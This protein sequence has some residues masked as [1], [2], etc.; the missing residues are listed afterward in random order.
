MT[1]DV[2]L[3]WDACDCCE[4]CRCIGPTEEVEVALGPLPP[5]RYTVQ[6]EGSS[7]VLD[8]WEPRACSVVNVDEVR[9]PTVLFDDQPFAMTL[10]ERDASSCSCQPHAS[11]DG[12]QARMDICDCCDVCDCIDRGYETSVASDPLPLGSRTISTSLGPRSLTVV[13]REQCGPLVPTGLRIVSPDPTLRSSGPAIHWAVVAG[14]ERLCCAPPAPAVDQG[15]GPAG[16]I[17]LALHSCV[18]ADCNCLGEEVAFEAW[19]PLVALPA[20]T[21]VI[22]A[23]T[24]EQ[25]ITIP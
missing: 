20:G 1:F 11:F 6:S 12:S 19:H 25:T 15:V 24:F 3:E 14:T 7:C 21:H 22:R 18:Q 23:G 4:G 16:Q 5:G 13:T 8:V 2:A 9:M 17:S 10:L